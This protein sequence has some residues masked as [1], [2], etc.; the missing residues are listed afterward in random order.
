MKKACRIFA[1]CLVCALCLALCAC[2][3]KEEEAI[4]TWSGTYEYNGNDFAVSFVLSANGKYSEVIYENGSLHSME[5]GTWEIDGG[6]VL[7]HEYGNM[8]ISTRYEYKGGKLV[9]NN[10][11]FTKN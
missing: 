10:H 7:L 2:G 4:G 3:I 5:E 1:L 9:N 11:E 8:G 6:D